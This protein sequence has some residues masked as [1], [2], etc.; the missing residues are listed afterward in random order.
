MACREVRWARANTIDVWRDRVS[1]EAL[2]I[3]MEGTDVACARG[4]CCV[5]AHA[6]CMLGVEMAIH[7]S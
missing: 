2:P 3:L 5:C 4:V 7:D 6:G 1:S